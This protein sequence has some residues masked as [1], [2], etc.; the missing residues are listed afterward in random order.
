VEVAVTFTLVCIGWTIFR[1]EDLYMA[2][3]R[4]THMFVPGGD[5]SRGARHA[6]LY[7]PQILCGMGAAA[8]IAFAGVPTWDLAGRITPA[9]VALALALFSASVVVLALNSS[10]PFL[11]FRF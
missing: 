5:L 4:V 11:Y 9:K 7:D 8:V 2:M 6:E 10:G 1:S 3:Y